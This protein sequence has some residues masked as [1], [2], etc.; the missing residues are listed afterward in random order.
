[1]ELQKNVRNQQVKLKRFAPESLAETDMEVQ[2]SEITLELNEGSNSRNDVLVKNLYLSCDPYMR[3]RLTGLNYSHHPPFQIGQVV[4]TSLLL[5]EFSQ[6]SSGFG[7][8]WCVEL[9]EWGRIW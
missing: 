7:C 6:L 2:A 8:W 3:H 4:F 9:C 1:M 5:S